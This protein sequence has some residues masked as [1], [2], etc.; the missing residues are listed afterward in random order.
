MAEK[1]SLYTGLTLQDISF[2][3]YQLQPA[4]SRRVDASISGILEER[5]MNWIYKQV[6]PQGMRFEDFYIAV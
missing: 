4:K 2:R 1:F 6:L 3:E 5:L